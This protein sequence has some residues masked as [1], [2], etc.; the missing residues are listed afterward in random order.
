MLTNFVRHIRIM[1][2][3]VAAIAVLGLSAWLSSNVASVV[4][5]FGSGGITVSA[6]GPMVVQRLQALNRLETA[7]QTNRDVVEA[8]AGYGS[9]PSLLGQDR[10][11]MVVQTEA[12]AGVDLSAL[13]PGDVAVDGKKA[14]LRLPA[15]EV[16]SVHVDDNGSRVYQRERGWLV[17]RPD[18]D[19][20]RQARLGAQRRARGA[21][22]VAGLLALART[23]AEGDLRGPAASAWYR[24]SGVRLA[25]LSGGLMWV[26]RRFETLVWQPGRR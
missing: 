7:R 20:E 5:S 22:S 18:L 17:F 11:L 12:V 26:L 1:L 4:R 16:F 14:V 25:G 2:Y 8:R 23:N 13:Q 15:P 24:R 9:L 3:A 21:E 10:L 19:L 6:P